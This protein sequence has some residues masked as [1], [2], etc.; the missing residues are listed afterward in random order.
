MWCS[1]PMGQPS[2]VG[3]MQPIPWWWPP[4]PRWPDC[5]A[6][7]LS[8][9]VMSPQPVQS[10][11][12]AAATFLATIMVLKRQWFSYPLLFGIALGFIHGHRVPVLLRLSQFYP[13][14]HFNH[15][16]ALGKCSNWCLSLTPI[17]TG[18]AHYPILHRG[19]GCPQASVPPNLIS[20]RAQEKH[21]VHKAGL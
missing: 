7:A 20:G 6:G 4:W 14:P 2:A 9:S 3:S 1:I 8:A 15:R 10:R 19:V 13:E 17:L 16:A 21:G 12:W 5:I 11:D 18:F